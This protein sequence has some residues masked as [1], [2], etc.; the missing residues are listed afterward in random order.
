MRSQLTKQTQETRRRLMLRVGLEIVAG[1]AAMAVLGG[2]AAPAFAQDSVLDEIKKRGELRVAG[3]T[4]RPFIARRPNGQYVGIDVDVMANVAKDL[5][6]KLTVVDSEWA[7]AVAGISSKKWDIVPA[8]CITPK[9]LEVVDFSESY[10]K[11]GGVFVTRKDNPRAFKTMEDFNKPEVV[12]AVPPGAWSESIA[13]AAAPKATLKAFGQ[14]T[15]SDLVIEVVA[16]RVDAVVLDAPVQTAVAM[17]AY[18]D[19]LAYY[20]SPT[21]PLDVLP[22]P[23]GYAYFKGDKKFGDFLNGWIQKG[24]KSGE[25]DTLFRKWLVPEHIKATN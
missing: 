15:S 16:G 3:V 14:S 19:I 9:R 25:L 20:P 13:K 24:K 1:A 11:L 8:T 12:F 10:L 6:V 23:V 18:K 22:C 7:T 21:Q 4:Y 17:D 5:G 2:A